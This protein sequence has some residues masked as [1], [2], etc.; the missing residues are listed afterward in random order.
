MNFTGLPEQVLATGVT[1]TVSTAIEFSELSAVKEAILPEP[2]AAM[3][4]VVLVLVQLYVAP[5][6]EPLKTTGAVGVLLHRV[7]LVGVLATG[8]GLTVTVILVAE[9]TQEPAVEVGVTL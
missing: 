9:P 5:D 1:V 8:T 6:T 3:P 2:V 7:W 4:I